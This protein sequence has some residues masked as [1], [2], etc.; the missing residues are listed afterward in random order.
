MFCNEQKKIVLR[1]KI[2]FEKDK[3]L[4]KTRH[5]GGFEDVLASD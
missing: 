4:S 1:A 2:D 5:Q 3:D